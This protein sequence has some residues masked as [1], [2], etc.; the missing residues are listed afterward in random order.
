VLLLLIAVG[1]AAG[2]ELRHDDS[3]VPTRVA[4]RPCTAPTITPTQ[5]VAPATTVRLPAPS[6]VTVTVL[7]GTTRQL[8]AKSV[9]DQL[10][11]DGFR[12]ARQ[13]NAPKALA[14][15]SQVLYGPGASLQARAVSAWVPGSAV[16]PAPKASRGSVQLVLGGSFTRLLTAA[17]VAARPSATAAPVATPTTAAC[18]S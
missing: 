15:A 16:V 7:N 12:I 1:G 17:Q 5:A 14:G 6:T 3:Q 9:A 10:A 2:W 11:A 13:G 18:A 8:L 4:R